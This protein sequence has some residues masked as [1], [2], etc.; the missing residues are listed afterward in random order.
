VDVW[1]KSALGPLSLQ[2][3]EHETLLT[4]RVEGFR[5]V[6]DNLSSLQ[7]RIRELDARKNVLRERHADLVNVRKVIANHE[8]TAT[9]ANAA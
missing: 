7:D 4:R 6:G 2:I 3:K 8:D 1:L 5:R 9:A